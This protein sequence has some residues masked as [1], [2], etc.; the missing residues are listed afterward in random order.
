MKSTFTHDQLCTL[1]GFSSISSIRKKGDTFTVTGEPVE[2]E[3]YG[4]ECRAEL[5][6]V[7]HGSGVLTRVDHITEETTPQD[8]Q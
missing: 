6:R 8:P 2:G 5:H 7:F 4:D 1:L 3:Q